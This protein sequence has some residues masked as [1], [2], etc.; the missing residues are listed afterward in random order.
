VTVLAVAAAGFFALESF[1]AKDQLEEANRKSAKVLADY[2][3]TAGATLS[4]RDEELAQARSEWA[5]K[6]K[7]LTAR[8]AEAERNRTTGDASLKAD[9]DRAKVAEIQAESRLATARSELAAA[10]QEITR[11]RSTTSASNQRTDDMLR[12]SSSDIRTWLTKQ[13]APLPM[14]NSQHEIRIALRKAEMS[15]L[16]DAERKKTERLVSQGAGTLELG[17]SESGLAYRA[18]IL[19]YSSISPP[20][21]ASVV[22]VKL[23]YR[24]SV[25]ES[26]TSL[27]PGDDDEIMSYT[28]VT[29]GSL[30]GSKSLHFDYRKTDDRFRSL[31]AMSPVVYRG[32]RTRMVF[33]LQFKEKGDPNFRWLV[34]KANTLERG[35]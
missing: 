35:K 5:T 26:A 29:G 2:E 8:V 20:I 6:E 34:F 10:K 12:S 33:C 19:K 27:D 18:A 7:D 3:A 1:K 17:N 9:A 4:Q 11:L 30:D 21:P 25:P 22:D 16:L 28:G 15:K 31:D 23:V 13:F 14:L 24:W 32:E